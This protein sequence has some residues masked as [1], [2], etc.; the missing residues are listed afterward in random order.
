VLTTSTSQSCAIVGGNTDSGREAVAC[1]LAL[2]RD[3]NSRD[4]ERLARWFDANSRVWIPPVRERIGAERILRLLRTIFVQYA[5][6]H[7]RP[8]CLY[9]V[10]PRVALVEAESWGLLLD[11]REYRNQM[12]AVH[13]FTAAGK[14]ESLSDYFKDVTSFARMGGQPDRLASHSQ[15][16]EAK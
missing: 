5:T 7:W 16:E 11:G 2:L 4:L 8:V 14:V 6:L 12:I 10:T 15:Q 13:R 1:S 3:M 9:A